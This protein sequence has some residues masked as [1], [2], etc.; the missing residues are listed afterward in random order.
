MTSEKLF[1][2]WGLP[3]DFLAHHWR[4]GHA[5]GRCAEADAP[6]RLPPAQVDA[7]LGQ[8]VRADRVSIST[9]G[10]LHHPAEFT[11]ARTIAGQPVADLVDEEKVRRLLDAGATVV[12]ANAEHWVPAVRELCGQLTEDFGC[13]VEAHVFRTGA[14]H[15]GLVPH[16]DGEDNFLLQL[17]GRKTWSLW[18][19]EGAAPSRAD[20]ANLGRPT[21]RVT[22]TPGDVLYI[23]VGWVHAA[24]AGEEGSTHITYQI[25]PD[26]LVDAV[27]AQL[28]DA[29]EELLGDRL[30]PAPGPPPLA[31]EAAADLAERIAELLR[32]PAH[33]GGAHPPSR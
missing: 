4:R 9:A 8:G 21:A 10:R 14:G 15:S 18:A 19:R 11:Q 22:L 29:L 12:L 23:P 5:L 13:E 30:L 6:G 27:L 16:A 20:P 32:H 31:R 26:T 17:D 3:P 25:L 24:T 1:T 2:A 28:G 7:L 33:P